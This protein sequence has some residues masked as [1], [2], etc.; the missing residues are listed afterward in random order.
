MRA[1]IFFPDH[2]SLDNFIQEELPKTYTYPEVGATKKNQQ[3]AHYD[4]D[5]NHH[6]GSNQNGYCKTHNGRD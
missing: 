2:P 1:S 5:N 6:Q 3:F 4:N